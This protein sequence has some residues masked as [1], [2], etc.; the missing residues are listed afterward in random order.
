MLVR[1]GYVSISNILKLSTSKFVTYTRF[2]EQKFNYGLIDN[3]IK[4]NL[5]NLIEILKYNFNNN[6]HFYRLSSSIIPLVTHESVNVDYVSKYKSYYNKISRIIN[7]NDI[8]IDL[9]ASSYCVLNSINNNV[10]KNSIED[11]IYYYN[12]LDC[13][14]VEKKIIILHVG[15]A[16][17]GKE[18]AIKR[19]INNF[20][21]LP[22]YIKKTIVLENDDKVFN[23]SD[24]LFISKAIGVPVCLDYHHHICNNISTDINFYMNDIIKSWDN[25]GIRPKFHYSSPLNKRNFR[26]HNDYIDCDEFISFLNVLQKYQVDVDIMIEAKEKD[27]AMFRLM[28]QLRYKTNYKF[29]DDTSFI[30]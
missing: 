18:E 24:V 26:A 2:S 21:K 17:G 7:D 13:F 4:S 11:L 25:Y 1:L 12:V 5:S 30:I 22:I 20:N 16:Y 23:V 10:V 28:R 9:H 15:S 27:V 3:V 8:R 29:I 6:V 14:G 19:F